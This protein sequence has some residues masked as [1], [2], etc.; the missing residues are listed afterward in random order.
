MTNTQRSWPRL[1]L[2][3]R[4]T[5]SASLEEWVIAGRVDVALLQDPAILEELRV[6]PVVTERLGLVV[7]VR[8]PLGETNTPVRA[9]DLSGLPMILPGPRHWIRRRV[10]N[11][12]FRRGIALDPLQQVESIA[13]TKEMVRNDLGCSI[14]PH[15]VVRD[16]IARGCLV[17]RPI[18]QMPLLAVHAIARRKET[19]AVPVIHQFASTLRDAMVEL[20]GQGAW[21]GATLIDAAPGSEVMTA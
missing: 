20:V 15:A 12:W 14:L 3:I 4:E 17:F 10:D 13:V 7:S 2:T 8:S 21:I 19:G 16:E 1:T 6:E 9:R 11:A 18:E 5:D